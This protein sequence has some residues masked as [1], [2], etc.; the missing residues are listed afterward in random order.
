MQSNLHHQS[1]PE[2]RSTV[3]QLVVEGAEELVAAKLCGCTGALSEMEVAWADKGRASA[4]AAQDV[5]VV[6]SQKTYGLDEV[7]MGYR[8]SCMLRAGYR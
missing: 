6:E 2:S 7:G 4:P 5:V 3:A 1:L 8:I